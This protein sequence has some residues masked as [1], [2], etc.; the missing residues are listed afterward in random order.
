MSSED[1]KTEGPEDL[2]SYPDLAFPPG[3]VVAFD[4]SAIDPVFTAPNEREMLKRLPH[5][6]WERR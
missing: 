3:L 5:C 1:V 4:H 2:R 6:D